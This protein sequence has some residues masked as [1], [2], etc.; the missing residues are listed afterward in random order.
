MKKEPTIDTDKVDRA[1][2]KVLKQIAKIF[3]EIAKFIGSAR[4]FLFTIPKKK[5][6]KIF[7]IIDIITLL[8][9]M[10]GVFYRM[11]R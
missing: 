1:I 9:F 10:L 11:G 3:S 6:D 8:M 7:R 5:M 2:I 4:R